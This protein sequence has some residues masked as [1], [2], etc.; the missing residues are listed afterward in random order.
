MIQGRFQ[1][2]ALAAKPGTVI[3]VGREKLHVP[4]SFQDFA[5]K[6]VDL[7]WKPLDS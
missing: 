5:K 3:F 1:M 7:T 6:T 2:I 4:K